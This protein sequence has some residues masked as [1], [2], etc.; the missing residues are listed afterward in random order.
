MTNVSC[1]RQHTMTQ[2]LGWW[3]ETSFLIQPY[4]DLPKHQSSGIELPTLAGGLMS[5]NPTF[6]GDNF[7]YIDKFLLC[8]FFLDTY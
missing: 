1:V 8:L 2:V 4:S 3:Y 7:S 5:G 6:R